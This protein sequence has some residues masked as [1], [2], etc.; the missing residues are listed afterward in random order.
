MFRRGICV[1]EVSVEVSEVMVLSISYPIREG[2]KILMVAGGYTLSAVVAEGHTS[3]SEIMMHVGNV[4]TEDLHTREI[5][6]PQ[7]VRIQV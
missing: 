2:C 5:K 6:K 3:L 4:Q 7:N 1:V